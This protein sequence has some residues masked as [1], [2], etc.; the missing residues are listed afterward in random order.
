M[1]R[2]FR[3]LF[4]LSLLLASVGLSAAPGSAG[5]PPRWVAHIQSFPG[6][7]SNGVRA[8]LA[9]DQPTDLRAAARA[10]TSDGRRSA[11]DPLQNVQANADCD[12][13]LPQN[14]TSVAFNVTN[15][16]NA[17]AAANDYCGDGYWMGFTT[18]G[19][20]TWGS[21]FKDPKTSNGERCFGSDPSVIYSRRDAA[22]YVSTLCFFTTSPISE[23]QVWKSVDGGATWTASTIASI[24]ITN[25]SADGTIDPSVFYDKE[26]MAVDNN[27]ASPHY[28]RIYVTFIKFHLVPP[29]GRSDYCPVQLAFTDSIPTA[30]PATATWSHAAVVPDMPGSGG[31]GPGANQWALPVVDGTGA[32]DVSYVSEDCNT[33]YDRAL[34]FTR[35][36][37]GGSSFGAPVRI[38]KPGQFADNPNR[39]DLLPAKSPRLPISPSMA[40]DPT[41]NRLLYVY[42]NNINRA[43]S[44]ADISLQVSNDLGGTW[45]NAQ[46]ISVTGNGAP[47]PEDQFF[48]WIAVDETGRY[49]AIWF[50]NRHDPANRL[51]ET[52]QALSTDGGASWTNTD[53]STVAWDPHDSFF[54]N[55]SF[56]GDYNGIAASDRVVY[57]VWTDGR[58]T[59]GPPLGQ[60]DIFTN[61]EIAP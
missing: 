33:A 22:F 52:F 38:D 17:V 54:T 47:A 34:F 36:T 5:S 56:I 37:N 58:N 8:R 30:D 24:A 9:A 21:I 26:L 53:I 15:P 40:F 6:G 39:K 44:G 1:A 18:D 19:G 59:P 51:I 14:E 20:R 2:A 11:A 23:V 3:S 27:P 29:S 57:P 41:R 13:P 61:V 60:T 25:R 45:S 43:A 12:P 28:G 4:A 16:M 10:A 55:G 35:S 50:D 7:I 49:H 42:Q 46:T 48:P 32:L 31:M